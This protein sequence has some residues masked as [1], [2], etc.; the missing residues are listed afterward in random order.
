MREASTKVATETGT[1]FLV[2]PAPSF[3][4]QSDPLRLGEDR[5]IYRTTI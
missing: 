3:F 4:K 2:P 5:G 1:L